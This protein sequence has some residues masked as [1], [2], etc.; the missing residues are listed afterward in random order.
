MS[1]SFDRTTHVYRSTTYTAI[2]DLLA[3]TKETL[4]IIHEELVDVPSN[5]PIPP[6][7][8]QLYTFAGRLAETLN[9]YR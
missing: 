9:F 8:V 1:L 3:V 7:I 4:A 2:E 6:E 5:E